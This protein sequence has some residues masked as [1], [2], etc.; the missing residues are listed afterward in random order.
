VLDLQGNKIK[1]A[2]HFHCLS[3]LVH[4]NLGKS[5]ERYWN[6]WGAKRVI[7]DNSLQEFAVPKA[8]PM[9]GLCSLKLAKNKLRTFDASYFPDLKTLYLDQNQLDKVEGLQN[10]KHLDSLSMREQ[11]RRSDNW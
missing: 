2:R 11:D 6:G 1:E 4:L 10:A 7:D 9:L 5:V 8:N 3:A